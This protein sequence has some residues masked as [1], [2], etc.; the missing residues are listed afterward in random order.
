MNKLATS[1]LVFSWDEM[2]SFEDE[3]QE[4]PNL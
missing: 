4:I 1:D 2:H 3:V